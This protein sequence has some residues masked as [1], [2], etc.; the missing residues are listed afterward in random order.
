MNKIIENDC[1]QIIIEYKNQLKKL[2]GKK[3]LITGGG[4]F[5]LSYFTKMLIIYNK[6]NKKKINI[7]IIDKF[8]DKTNPNFK[9]FNSSKNVFILKRDVSLIKNFNQNFNYIIHGASIA[10]PVIYKKFPIETI[11]SNVNGLLNILECY[12]KNKKLKSLIFMSSSEI[13]GDPDNANIPTTEYYLGNVSCTGPRAC[14]DESKRLGE[15]IATTFFKKYKLPIK[16]IRPF[17]VYGPGQKLDDGRIIPDI[18]KKIIEKRNIVLYSNGKSTRSFC[19]ISDQ[20]RGLIEI[21]FKGKDGESY[22]VGNDKEVSIMEVSKLAIKLS[23]TNI[24]IKKKI[25]RDKTFNIDSPKRRC[26]NIDKLK[27]INNWK[28][29]INL[30]NGLLKTINSYKE[31]IN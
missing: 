8:L 30:K 25:S 22:N 13:Y 14:Y 18:I 12:K 28:P 1:E 11:K 31:A 24:K 3:I 20:V 26:P 2:L 6:K 21:M 7:T 17:N 23:N 10:S 19:Y 29:K 15:T 27:K 16:I 9:I 5:L 4:G